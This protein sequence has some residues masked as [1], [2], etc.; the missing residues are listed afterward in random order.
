VPAEVTIA[1]GP[2]GGW[3][4]AEI[5]AGSGDRGRDPIPI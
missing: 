1:I 5:P 4:S 2:E 3:D